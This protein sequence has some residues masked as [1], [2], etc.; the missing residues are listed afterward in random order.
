MH[1][2]V[3]RAVEF[4][5]FEVRGEHVATPVG[6][7]A[8]QR[9]RGVLA[10]DQIEVGVIGHAIAFVRGALDLDDAAR[11]VP[12]PANIGGHVRKQEIV[13]DRMPDRSFGEGEAGAELADGC[14]R[15]DQVLEFGSQRG[16]GHGRSL[17]AA[18]AGNQLRLGS[19][20]TIGPGTWSCSRPTTSPPSILHGR[21]CTGS[22]K[23]ELL[24]SFLMA[25]F[26]ARFEV[27]WLP[28]VRG[29]A[30]WISRKGS[31]S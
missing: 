16:V 10:D 30:S 20:C 8:D 9:R 22:R 6:A 5:V 2:D 17:R 3:V 24:T 1:A 31:T 12:A 29:S 11:G 18:Q 4:L 19:D 7:L 23:R 28:V 25:A 13:T 27:P 26:S 15:V 21:S 14:I